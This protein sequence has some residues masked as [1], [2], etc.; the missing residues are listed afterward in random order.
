MFAL[1]H[2]P[3]PRRT[4][5]TGAPRNARRSR[6]LGTAAAAAVFMLGPWAGPAEAAGEATAPQPRAVQV[7]GSV[8]EPHLS[9]AEVRITELRAKVSAMAQAVRNRI[10]ADSPAA[11]SRERTAAANTAPAPLAPAPTAGVSGAAAAVGVAPDA[12]AEDAAEPEPSIRAAAVDPPPLEAAGPAVLAESGGS[13]GPNRTRDRTRRSSYRR[14][15]SQRRF[16]VA[17]ADSP[18]RSG[19]GGHLPRSVPAHRPPPPPTGPGMPMSAASGSSSGMFFR[20]GVAALLGL[21]ACEVP[22]APRRRSVPPADR[23]SAAPF[24][25]RLER[26]G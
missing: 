21:M 15:S 5:S 1:V 25:P 14:T 2:G 16:T 8:S 13:V 11:P 10:Q 17:A 19:R 23:P 3:G 7:Q 22:G 6:A 26:P 24:I 9:S 12:P 4:G 20:I 18:A